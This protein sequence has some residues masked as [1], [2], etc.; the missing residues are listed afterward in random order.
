MIK[1][2][3][4]G[5][6]AL[7]AICALL[8]LGA[9]GLGRLR[10]AATVAVLE[11]DAFLSRLHVLDVD[12]PGLA[13]SGA[14]NIALCALSW[15]SAGRQLV[16]AAITPHVSTTDLHLH[17]LDVLPFRAPLRLTTQDSNL[18]PA[19][20]P[21][22][23][24]IAFVTLRD[25]AASV[26]IGPFAGLNT[27]SGARF[28]T[29]FPY[30]V[31]GLRWSP[32]GRWLA[33]MFHGYGASLIDLHTTQ[34]IPLRPGLLEL[35]WAPD[36]ALL[37]YRVDVAMGSPPDHS[38]YLFDPV[39]GQ[40][41]PLLDRFRP[42]Q[43]L[44]FSPDGRVLAAVL[45]GEPAVIVRISLPDGRITRLEGLPFLNIDTLSWAPD[46]TRLL[47]AATSPTPTRQG[48]RQGRT[49]AYDLYTLRPD[50]TGLRRVLRG[51]GHAFGLGSRFC[52]AAWR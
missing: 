15:R 4:G 37:A 33:A 19:V 13:Q 46:G 35:T 42:A 18:A 21:D 26:W 3:C 40:E 10:P 31:V 24:V 32:D 47:L 52:P 27:Q 30:S 25:K 23:R 48:T 5:L 9:V 6:V 43:S 2:G 50:G 17:T 16:Y 36:R 11:Y 45:T 44:A 34:V 28:I 20:S 12:H 8:V 39:Q 38:V 51:S 7:T 41:W 1:H 14:Y 49:P 29:D 22:G